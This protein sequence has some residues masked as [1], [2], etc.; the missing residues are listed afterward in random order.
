MFFRA[1]Q[2]IGLPDVISALKFFKSP[3]VSGWMLSIGS[4]EGKVLIL[5]ATIDS[6][7]PALPLNSRKENQAILQLFMY[8]DVN[9][10]N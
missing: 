7:T 2:C 5:D 8:S 6:V 3:C 10:Q 1:V 9:P 4:K